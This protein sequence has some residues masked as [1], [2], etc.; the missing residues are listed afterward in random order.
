MNKN[1]ESENYNQLQEAKEKLREALAM[2]QRFDLKLG[3]DGESSTYKS[4]IRDI[5]I[6]VFPNFEDY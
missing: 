5:I 2:I 3:G 4:E 6:E 1:S